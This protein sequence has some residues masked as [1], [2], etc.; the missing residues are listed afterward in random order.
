[1]SEAVNEAQPSSATSAVVAFDFDGTLTWRDTLLPFLRRLLGTFNF[2]WLLL[3]CSPWLAAFALRLMSNH[4]AKA[5]LLHA[6]LAGRSV[7]EVQRC[8]RAFVD[9]ELPAQWRPWALRQFVQQQQAG[10]RCVLVSAS[11]SLYMPLVGQSLGAH[12]VL[13]TEME[14]VDGRY[15]GRLST[16]NCHGEE[17]VRRLRTW[18]A[19]EDAAANDTPTPLLQAYGDTSGDLPMLRMAQQAWYRERPW[20]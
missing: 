17:K 8:A 14:I 9:R 19:T 16:P 3:V 15:T 20:P 6:A 2:L 13:C 5:K 7:D 18:L 10:H 11:T 12:A 4:R 1:M